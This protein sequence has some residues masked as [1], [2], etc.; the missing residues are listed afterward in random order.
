LFRPT[1]KGQGT[2]PSHAVLD[3]DQPV[4]YQESWDSMPNLIHAGYAY[5]AKTG[6]LT[7]YQQ[8]RDTLLQVGEWISRLDRDADGLPD[9]DIF[10]FGYYDSV[11]K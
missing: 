6:D 1:G 2:H 5:V 3:W 10:H 8:H 11:Q 9:R 4:V 7:F